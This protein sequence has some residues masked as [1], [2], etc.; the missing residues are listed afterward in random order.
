MRQ[1]L[2]RRTATKE[3]AQLQGQ[4]KLLLNNLQQFST[5]LSR[6]IEVQR[7]LTVQ[8]ASLGQQQLELAEGFSLNSDAHRSLVF[9]GEKLLVVL[10]LV[11]Q[12]IRTLVRCTFDDTMQT[13]KSMNF[14]RIEYD[15][16]RR[17]YETLQAAVNKQKQANPSSDR[18]VDQVLARLHLSG[19]TFTHLKT[20]VD[21]KI[22]LLHENRVRVMQHNLLLLHR[23]ITAYFSGDTRKLD[24]TMRL[25]CIRTLSPAYN[26]LLHSDSV[27]IQPTESQSLTKPPDSPNQKSEQ[28]PVEVITNGIH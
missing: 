19:Q 17:E 21:T 7:R 28:T 3:V 6:T 2:I 23:S 14:A 26:D 22:R 12:A 15:A 16:N 18:R 24:E 9:N 5:S 13:V 20:A 10:D 25:F 4:Y 11:C 27:C 8:L 1:G